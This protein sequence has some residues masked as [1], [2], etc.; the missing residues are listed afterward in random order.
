[1]GR[2]G[3]LRLANNEKIEGEWLSNSLTAK[4]IHT[5]ANGQ[6]FEEHYRDGIAEGSRKPLKRTGNFSLKPKTKRHNTAQ[7]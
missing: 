4:A 7:F 6:R 3:T 2:Y 1:M 5:E